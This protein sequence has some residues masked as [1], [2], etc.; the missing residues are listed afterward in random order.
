LDIKASIYEWGRYNQY[1]AVIIYKLF[2][3]QACNP[4]NS[5]SENQKDWGSRQEP[6]EKA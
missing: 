1:I 3:V 5:K 6:R 4:S 2:E